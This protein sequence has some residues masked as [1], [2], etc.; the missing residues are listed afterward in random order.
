MTPPALGTSPGTGD[1]DY[2]YQ[3]NPRAAVP[4]VEAYFSRA[5]SASA[6]A[7]ESF[8]CQLD[9]RYGSGHLMTCD[10]FPAAETPTP[11]H[12]FFHGG[13]WR[14]RDKADYSY[15]ANI[16]VP[17]GI[18][19]VI[20]NYDL[21]PNVLLP[22][23]VDEVKAF[24]RWL[25]EAIGNMG[26]DKGKVTAS[27]H[28]AG[29]HLLSMAHADLAE[30]P[31]RHAVLISGIYDLEPVLRVSINDVIGLDAHTAAA[32]SPLRRPHTC[33]SCDVVVGGAETK[34]WIAQSRSF[35]EA[36]NASGGR[37]SYCEI[38]DQNHFSIMERLTDRES[39]L[40]QLIV[41]RALAAG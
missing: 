11:V 13:Y 36:V 14:G 33:S 10:V 9:V 25:P 40:S 17:A 24:F 15:L 2:E 29:A 26:G 31:L 27:G 41:S 18:T 1:V 4:D 37:A 22:D 38:P 8:N 5:S 21:C 32:M 7:R 39:N 20:A 23:I 6:R 30:T 16:L 19:A 34:A 3:Y 35:A 12:A 28:S